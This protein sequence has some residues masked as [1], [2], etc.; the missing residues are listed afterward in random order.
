MNLLSEWI[1]QRPE[2]G[3]LLSWLSL[4][5]GPRACVDELLHYHDRNHLPVG[6]ESLVCPLPAAGGW[7]HSLI[8][9]IDSLFSEKG[10]VFGYKYS[11]LVRN[12]ISS[13]GWPNVASSKYS[14]T[15]V[16]LCS[17][18]VWNKWSELFLL[19]SN[20]GLAFLLLQ[21]PPSF[22]FIRHYKWCWT[23]LFSRYALPPSPV[24]VH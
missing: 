20:D 4:S 16:M 8:K 19:L 5:G 7:C 13:A 9:E 1:E 2:C 18:C 22:S 17:L 14:K 6:Y 21:N 11:M 3:M 23:R 10:Q 15:V 12:Q 24:Q